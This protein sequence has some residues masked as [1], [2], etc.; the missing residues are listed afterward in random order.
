MIDK[1]VFSNLVNQFNTRESRERNPNSARDSRNYY[2]RRF[3]PSKKSLAN[4]ETGTHEQWR[5]RTIDRAIR[6]LRARLRSWISYGTGASERR[7]QKKWTQNDTNNLFRLAR[8]NK[9]GPSLLKLFEEA[10]PYLPPETWQEKTSEAFL[11][12][13][14]GEEARIEE[15]TGKGKMIATQ[16][17]RKKMR[18]N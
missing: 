4:G 14:G 18:T 13:G 10:R 9:G 16:S 3:G 8:E 5:Q 2:H 1:K 15:K 6:N 7:P 17:R 12:E 11:R